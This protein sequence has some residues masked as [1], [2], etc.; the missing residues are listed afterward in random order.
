MLLH[1]GLP[2]HL[3]TS[4]ISNKSGPKAS[5]LPFHRSRWSILPTRVYKQDFLFPLIGIKVKSSSG[6]GS[7]GGG[8]HDEKKNGQF[9]IQ[10]IFPSS[11]LVEHGA[12]EGDV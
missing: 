3:Q 9:Y 8:G 11:P 5:L 4:Q 12:A 6:G 7:G 2:Q 10:E 1:P